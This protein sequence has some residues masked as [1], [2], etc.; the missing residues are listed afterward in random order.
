MRQEIEWPGNL[1]SLSIMKIFDPV[2][3]EGWR[4]QKRWDSIASNTVAVSIAK[5]RDI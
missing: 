3:E 1:E 5:K 2:G 4:F